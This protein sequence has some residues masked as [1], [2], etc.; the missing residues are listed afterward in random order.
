M[1]LFGFWVRNPQRDRETDRGRFD[2]L[3]Q[4]FLELQQ[5][6]EAERD[7]LHTRYERAQN[8]AAFALEAFENGDGGQLALKADTLAD[9]IQRYGER[10][11]ALERQ[12]EFMRAAKAEA[13]DF[14]NTLSV[15]ATEGPRTETAL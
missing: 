3:S 9:A 10:L 12:I 6:I 5:E 15:T 7:G 2:R 4:L 1:A 11:E 14:C 13:D 8:S